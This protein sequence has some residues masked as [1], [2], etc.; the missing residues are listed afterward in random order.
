MISTGFES[1]IDAT[2]LVSVCWNF[3]DVADNMERGLNYPL[4]KLLTNSLINI[5]LEHRQWFEG[6][7]EFDIDAICRAKSIREFD[8]AF[9]I[10]MFNF[11]S[12][13]DYYQQASHKGKIAC[14]K[15]PTFCIN[16]ADDMFAPATSKWLSP[17]LHN[18]EG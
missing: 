18:T 14:I 4:T 15:K 10:R 16:A 6:R 3:I 12:S 13:N 17:S 9:T 1:M 5:V 8:E 11:A 2:F 7:P